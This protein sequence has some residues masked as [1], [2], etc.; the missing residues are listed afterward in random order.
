M[1]KHMFAATIQRAKKFYKCNACREW[2]NSGL[3]S[4]DITADAQLII[5]AAAADGYKIR[6][7]VEYIKEIGVSADGWFT[8]RSRIDMTTLC[9]EYDVFEYWQNE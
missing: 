6:P 7:G 9:Y 8:L 1:S 5:D 2:L 3:G 4:R